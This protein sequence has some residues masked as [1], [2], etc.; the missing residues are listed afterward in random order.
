[1]NRRPLTTLLIGLALTSTAAAEALQIGTAK[2]LF[3]DDYI[4]ASS[5]GVFPVLNQPVKYTGNPVLELK[6]DQQVGGQELIVGQGSVIYDGEEKLFKMWY[7]GA[8]YHWRNNVVAY[9]YSKDG[10][11]WTLPNLGLV[12]YNGSKENNSVLHTGRGEMAPGWR[13]DEPS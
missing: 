1:M 8:T 9:A 6:P 7:E 4:I 12:E 2:Q 10:I 13:R 11:H 3:L 5:E